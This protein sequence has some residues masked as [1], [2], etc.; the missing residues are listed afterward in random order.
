NPIAT[1]IY[2]PWDRLQPAE[3]AAQGFQGSDTNGDHGAIDQAY[4]HCGRHH[5]GA[6]R[7]RWRTEL[8]RRRGL[9]SVPA[10]RPHHRLD[11]SQWGRALGARAGRYQQLR[12]ER[13]IGLVREPADDRRRDPRRGGEFSWLYRAA[14]AGGCAPRRS[15]PALRGTDRVA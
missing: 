6:A 14:V 3:G 12:L 13:R 11:R 4:L 1:L 2:S 15:A 5:A 8:E 7:G 9:V 10:A